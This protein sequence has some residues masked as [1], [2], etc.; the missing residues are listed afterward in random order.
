MGPLYGQTASAAFVKGD[1]G[2][3][4]RRRM[5]PRYCELITVGIVA[6]GQDLTASPGWRGL[7]NVTGPIVVAAMD[8]LASLRRIGLHHAQRG[9]RKH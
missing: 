7:R 5:S 2:R 3:H 1:K 9:M 6:L 4:G 8:C